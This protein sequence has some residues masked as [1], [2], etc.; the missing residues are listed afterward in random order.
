MTLL[1]SA[2]E[3]C[4]TLMVPTNDLQ[5]LDR[6]ISVLAEFAARIRWE[7]WVGE[8]L[9]ITCCYGLGSLLCSLHRRTQKDPEGR[10]F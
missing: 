6:S 4:Y 10:M 8:G 9:E 5:L 3:T 2:D 1:W 7:M